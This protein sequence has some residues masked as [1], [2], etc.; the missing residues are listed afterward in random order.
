MQ[1]ADNP[2]VLVLSKFSGAAEDLEEAVLVNPYDTDEMAI[3][4]HRA[5]TMSIEERR[6]RYEALIERVRGRDV[7]NW[8]K[9]FLDAL[10]SEPQRQCTG[11]TA[12]ANANANAR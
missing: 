10:R 6:E 7:T 8:R 2:G 4:L 5:L 11:V 9:T 3:A 1:D 12:L